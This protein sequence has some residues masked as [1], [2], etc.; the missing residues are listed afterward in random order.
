MIV[1]IAHDRKE[2]KDILIKVSHLAFE[3]GTNI[4]EWQPEINSDLASSIAFRV[5]G[6]EL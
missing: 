4:D 6:N 5:A 3:D 2:I 1:S